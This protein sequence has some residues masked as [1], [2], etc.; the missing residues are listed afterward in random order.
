MAFSFGKLCRVGVYLV[1]LCVSSELAGSDTGLVG[2]W[3]IQGECLDHSGN[4]NDGVN[5]HVDLDSSEFNGRE[6]YI[7]VPTSPSLNFGG[8]AI[9]IAAWVYTEPHL[10]DLFGNVVS[11]FDPAERRGFHLT[12]CSSNPGY[13]GPSNVRNVFFGL[14]CGTQ[15]KWQECGRPGEAHV[16]DALTVFNGELYVGTTD[17]DDE[18]DWAHVYRY[19][20]NQEW[21]D[22][23]RLG[24]GR[25]RGVYA[26]VVHDGQLYAATAA[27]HGPQPPGFDFG[28]VYRYQG[29]TSWEDIGQPGET[30]RL[31][32][33][34]SFNGKLYVTA[35]NIGGA[36]GHVHVYDGGR[37]WRVSGEF[38]GNP[39]TLTVHDG[40]LFA[41]Y[42]N[43]EVFAF[44]GS[45]WEGL[46]NPLGSTAECSQIHSLGVYNDDLYAGTWPLGKV[47]VWRD[48]TWTDLGRLGDATEV[49]ALTTYNGSFYAGTIPRAEVFRY[50]GPEQ[51]APIRRLFDPPGFEPVPVGGGGAGVA[52]WSRASSLAVFQGRLFATTATCYRTKIDVPLPNETRGKVYAFT[53]GAGVSLDRDLG[54]GWKH[55]TA[56]RD[57]NSLRLY[58]DGELQT[59]AKADIEN[60]DVTNDV[61]LRIGFGPEAH[62][63]GRI[64][65]VRLYNRA[66]TEP[67]IKQLSLDAAARTAGK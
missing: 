33:L 66:L 27:S 10:D 48:G 21:E 11:K 64:R 17:G 52:D 53:A 31:H 58:V 25:T 5:H 43:G 44:D 2:Y 57:G 16:S 46:G 54:A 22:C 20:G 13:N 34:A 61:P 4:G 15:G 18:A 30:L 19:R 49:T 6:S 9:S 14:D 55:I 37:S 26:M 12:I 28:R 59:T 56:L 62:F 47:A 23:G 38:P 67:E 42:P 63:R 24:T 45:T 3:K 51:W 40:R 35:F 65:E 7:E 8:N 1:V 39:H 50:D 29:G 60:L 32:S 36:A 41:A